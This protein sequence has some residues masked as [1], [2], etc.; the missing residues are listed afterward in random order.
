MKRP[1]IVRSVIMSIM[2]EMI[3]MKLHPVLLLVPDTKI[4]YPE[5]CNC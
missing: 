5:L 1:M 2:T 4:G 3:I